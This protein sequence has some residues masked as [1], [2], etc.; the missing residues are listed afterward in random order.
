M[1]SLESIWIIQGFSIL[2]WL[3]FLIR[4]FFIVRDI[5]HIVEGI[6]ATLASSH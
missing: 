6:V 5:V 3:T 2:A 1:D 4:W